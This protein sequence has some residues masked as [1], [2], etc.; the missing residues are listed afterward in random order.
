MATRKAVAASIAAAILFS[1]M[2]VSNYVIFSGADE[3]FRLVSIATEAREF[4]VQATLITDVAVLDLLDGAQELLSSG[5]FYCS[6]A[7]ESVAKVIG[8]E[9]VLLDWGGLRANTTASLAPDEAVPDNLTGL[10]PFN[11]SVTGMTNL[12]AAALVQGMSPDGSVQ[13]YRSEQHLLNIPL[14]LGSLTEHCLGA[15]AAL[16]AALSGFEGRAC[17][18]SSVAAVVSQVASEVSESASADGFAVSVSYSIV[19][20]QPCKVGYLIDAEQLGVQGPEGAF[21][22]TEEESGY[23]G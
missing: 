22:F 13:Y 11:G 16:S 20:A 12:R 21:A 4:R 7:S 2:I 6:N 23:L 14:R 5:H 9:E 17:N 19:S 8:S 3:N 1:S 15:E 10:H 18:S